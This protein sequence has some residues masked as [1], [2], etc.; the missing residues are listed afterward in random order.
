MKKNLLGWSMIAL[1]ITSFTA[2]ESNSVKDGAK[3]T[4]PTTTSILT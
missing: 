2:C 3:Y 1:V 4:F